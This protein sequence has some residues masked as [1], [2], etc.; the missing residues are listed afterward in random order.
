MGTWEMILFTANVLA[1]IYFIKKNILLGQ[2]VAQVIS[3]RESFYFNYLNQN[4]FLKQIDEEVVKRLEQEVEIVREK[5]NTEAA[6]KRMKAVAD[7]WYTQYTN[8]NFEEMLKEKLKEDYK[9]K[10]KEAFCP[11]TELTPYTYG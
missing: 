5:L 11:S 2:A 10:M 3:F 8:E 1:I 6:G 4:D 7:E 9:G